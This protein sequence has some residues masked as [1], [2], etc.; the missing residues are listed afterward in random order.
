MTAPIRKSESSPRRKRLAILGATGS[1][2][3]STLDVVERHPD[4]YSVHALTAHKSETKLLELCL[5]FRPEIAV[6]SGAQDAPVMQS[7]LR[8][9]GCS[10]TLLFG[11]SSLVDAVEGCD[12]VMAAI[13]GAAGLAP[14]LRAAQLGKQVMLA[15][16]E[17]LVMAGPV[18]MR[19]VRQS[20][21]CLLPIDSE[22][23]AVF[24][25]MPSGRDG[26]TDTT[27]VSRIML[28]AS[29]GPFRSLPIDRFEH[30]TPEQA[31]AH[32]NWSMGRKISVDSATMMNKGLE[33]IE[34]CLLFGVPPERVQVLIHPQSIIHS[35]VEY[36]DGSVLAQLSN[37]DMRIPI[38][39]ALAFPER[40][41]SGVTPLDLAAIG[42]LQFEAPDMRRFPCLGLAFQALKASGTAPAILNASNEIAVEAF[43]AGS[44]PFTAIHSIVEGALNALGTSGAET[45]EEIIRAD[46]LAREVS[47]KLVARAAEGAR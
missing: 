5:R 9:A 3:L 25:C 30:V 11:A 33:V 36:L 35:M 44:V 6:L 12:A 45:L 2:G 23:N 43:L 41:T 8:K 4:R 16:K 38:A 20:A 26:R 46:A 13:V 14:T 19:Y 34:A 21:A 42:T 15:N 40:T 32:P 39:H 29:G 10:T 28:T 7:E 22:H 31:C 37:P 24:Q 1:I 27:F 18:F 17:A 47:A